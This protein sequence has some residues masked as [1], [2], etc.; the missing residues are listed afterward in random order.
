METVDHQPAVEAEATPTAWN[1]LDDALQDL[2]RAESLV[3]LL[4]CAQDVEEHHRYAAEIAWELL[5][6][7]KGKVEAA[8]VLMRASSQASDQPPHDSIS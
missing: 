6:A 2:V 7:L 1:L 4:N 3:T 5:R 8:Q